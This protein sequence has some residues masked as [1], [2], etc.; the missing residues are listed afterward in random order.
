MSTTRQDVLSTE[1]TIPADDLLTQPTENL[2]TQPTTPADDLPTQPILPARDVDS[3]LDVKSTPDATIDITSIQAKLEQ[4]A[5]LNRG[6]KLVVLK[7][8][9]NDDEAARDFIGEAYRK[10]YPHAYSIKYLAPNFGSLLAEF[11]YA[12][13]QFQ[14]STDGTK[15]FSDN[16]TSLPKITYAPIGYAGATG[17]LISNVSTFDF[18]GEANGTIAEYA[19]SESWRVS[20]RKSGAQFCQ[21]PGKSLLGMANYSVCLVHNVVGGYAD[22]IPLDPW[23][24]ENLDPVTAW[25]VRAAFVLLADAYYTRYLTPN[26]DR[27]LKRHWDDEWLTGKMLRGQFATPLHVGFQ[28]LSATFLRSLSFIYLNP[29]L[30]KALD[31]NWLPDN[32]TG[33]IVAYHTLV[34]RFF[35]TSDRYY[36]SLNKTK[37][38]IKDFDSKAQDQ[39]NAIVMALTQGGQDINVLDQDVMDAKFRTA[40]NAAKKRLNPEE[41]S[42]ST[43]DLIKTLSGELRSQRSCLDTFQTEYP[44]IIMSGIR[45]AVFSYLADMAFLLTVKDDSVGPQV[46]YYLTG[47]ALAI[48]IC[49]RAES[50]RMSYEVVLKELEAHAREALQGG[51]AHARQALQSNDEEKLTGDDNIDEEAAQP[52]E[53]VPAKTSSCWSGLTFAGIL[54]VTACAV[55]QMS[56]AISNLTFAENTAVDNGIDKGLAVAAVAALSI[57]TAVNGF[58]LNAGKINST[59]TTVFHNT[60]KL[61]AWMKPSCCTRR[62]EEVEEPTYQ[63]LTTKAS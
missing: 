50:E 61:L 46:G 36:G 19:E 30:S 58:R 7:H 48:F 41:S 12:L 43:Y 34:S 56:R 13:Y 26:F 23:L 55:S 25:G 37:S 8:F 62:A 18:V 38:L 57:E 24:N 63:P 4:G 59:M 16:I 33:L 40:S 10:F 11:A 9:K 2:P 51:E 15:S 60:G 53:P 6:E 47:A 22:V 3:A 52:N 35:S 44:A 54:G 39:Q 14:T 28:A 29:Y 32:V 21:H 5:T 27:G 31:N 42:K 45:G 17:D 1:P 20:L 49:Y